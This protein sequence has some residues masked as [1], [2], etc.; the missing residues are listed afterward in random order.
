MPISVG[1]DPDNGNGV[2]HTC[3]IDPARRG[4]ITDSGRVCTFCLDG[5]ERSQ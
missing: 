4:D 3:S 1:Q 2:G 5:E